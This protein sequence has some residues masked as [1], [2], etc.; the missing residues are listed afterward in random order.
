MLRHSSASES[1]EPE[2]FHARSGYRDVCCF[3]SGFGSTSSDSVGPPPSYAIV[4][5]HGGPDWQSSTFMTFARALA[6]G[7]RQATLT[8]TPESKSAMVQQMLDLIQQV[9]AAKDENRANGN[10]SP[11]KWADLEPAM[12][13]ADYRQPVSTFMNFAQALALGE[14][15]S[16][17][18]QAPP[19]NLGQAAQD[20]RESKAADEQAAVVIK[21]D[22][23]G[24]PV[25]VHRPPQ[26]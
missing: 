18:E 14:Q 17:Q 9:R 21:Q 16:V 24:H 2:K 11:V 13:P 6:E 5:A 22:A 10:S 20:E 1:K 3:S 12:N 26:P 8:P 23:K 19:L 4:G 7:E 15:E 25:V